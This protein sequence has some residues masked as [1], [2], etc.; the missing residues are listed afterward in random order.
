M[1]AQEWEKESRLTEEEDHGARIR[2]VDK[3]LRQKLRREETER[4][5]RPQA[6]KLRSMIEVIQLQG[7]S[8]WSMAGISLPTGHVGA[9]SN[10]L[11]LLLSAHPRERT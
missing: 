3:E 8:I 11:T 7:G 9:A 4:K 1:Q 2:K 10:V 6:D 5:P